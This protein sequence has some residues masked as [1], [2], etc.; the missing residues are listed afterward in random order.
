ML[1]AMREGTGAS[2]IK[3][4]ALGFVLCASLGMIFMD[5]GGFFRGGIS[6]NKTLAQVG[7]TRI[8]QQAFERQAQNVLRQQNMTMQEA[9]RF[10][11]VKALLDEMVT[12]EAVRQEATDEGLRISRDEIAARVHQMVST[13]IQPGED[14]QTTLNRLLRTQGMTEADLVSSLRT[15]LTAQLIEKPLNGA[16]SYVPKLATEALGRYQAERRDI[17]FF[18]MTAEAAGKDVHA[19]DETLR[20][21]YE[22]VKDQYQIPEERT[23][24]VIVLSSDDIKGNV[25]ASDADV[26]AAYD[27]R[28]DQ[29]RI[30][31][32]R[33][34]EQ[35][36]LSD[37]AKAKAAAEAAR[38]GKP[39]KSTAPDSYREPAD[40]EQTTL[41]VGLGAAVFAAEK[42]TVLNPIQTP[43]GWHVIRIVSI[44][45]SREQSFAEVK[46]DL[47][48]E[49]ESDALHEEMESRISKVDESLG[50][51]ATLEQTASDSG[52]AI[53]TVGPVDA[54]GSFKQDKTND[55]FLTALGGNKDLLNS[56][57][58]LME[59]ETG[60]LAEVSEGLYAA[61][62]LEAVRP[63][64]DR[65]FEDVK[66]ELEKKYLDEERGKALNTTVDKM[67]AELSKGEKTFEQAAAE[68]G[69]VVKTA[70]DV[71]RTSKVAGLNDPVALTRLFDETDLNAVVKVPSEGNVIL[72]KVL[73]ARIPA[74]G[75]GAITPEQE[76]QARTQMQQALR[77]IFFEDVRK[78]QKVKIHDGTLEKIYGAESTDA[79]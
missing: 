47:R 57:F 44:T 26:K 27:E 69:A 70:R 46:N 29:F 71:S 58:E 60:D 12:R 7:R 51:G 31:E 2:I 63:T 68:A 10:G 8:D 33:K 49:L 54:Q 13:Q 76:N 1:N 16:G 32:R 9:Y 78:R 72:A 50:S 30:G 5:V 79:Q 40:V 36:V 64:Q 43:L 45:P 61:F 14:A 39:L 65:A 56:L 23:F 4:V 20:A 18:T 48:K 24:K 22:G 3:Y 34:I 59:G 53:R 74:A 17:T 62:S 28:K 37:E 19:D 55:P 73:N 42:G 11:I 38:N 35:V 75:T 25:R 66:S 15:Q 41:P 6:G 67:M 77:D 52:L 21:Y